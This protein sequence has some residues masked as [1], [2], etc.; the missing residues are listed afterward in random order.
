[1]DAIGVL[2]TL[3]PKLREGGGSVLVIYFEVKRLL[4][5]YQGGKRHLTYNYTD[6]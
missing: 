1:M 5:S 3:I 6:P 4:S 2:F